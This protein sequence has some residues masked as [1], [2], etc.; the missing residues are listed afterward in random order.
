[1][2]IHSLFTCHNW[3]YGIWSIFYNKTP[4]ASGYCEYI[5]ANIE[6][7]PVIDHIVSNKKSLFD[8]EKAAA[9][10]FWYKKADRADKSIIKYFPEY[11][12]CVNES[13]PLFNS[14]YG[15]YANNGLKRCIA[16]LKVN[17]NSR[18]A[19]FMINNNDAMDWNSIDKLCTN[20]IMFF[21]Q[22]N[23]LK[24]IVQMRS[25]NA[26]TLL[27]YDNFIFCTWYAKVYN[28]LIEEYP[29]LL[30][31]TLEYQIANLHFFSN[32]LIG[33]SSYT[34]ITALDSIFKKE[35]LCSHNF[36]LELEKKLVSFFK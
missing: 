8:P 29:E 14:N 34:S 7:D 36:E 3:K 33:K 6:I 23:K 28:A 35:D 31:S 1:M 25:S 32:D 30:T 12:R 27:P 26:L 16:V 5:G 9:M 20:A 4:D 11:K 15:I 13:H 18:H 10:Y 22:N 21:I 2:E 19:C 24:M 17:R